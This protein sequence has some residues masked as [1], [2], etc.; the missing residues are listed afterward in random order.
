MS[1]HDSD[2]DSGA[3]FPPELAGLD[4]CYVSTTGRRSG[5][6]HRIEIW[7][8]LHRDV[9][10][11]ICGNG[12]GADWFQNMAAHPT[13][14]VELG[15]EVREGTAREVTDARERRLVGELLGA[16]HQ[17]WRGD[18]DIG[19]TFEAWCFDV[20]AVAIDGWRSPAAE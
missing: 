13:V 4:V 20:P 17:G 18:P 1:P 10:Y 15:H 19:L 6:I 2:S 14:T 3:A 11:L 5:R 12:P 16:K 7:F 8:A 9:L